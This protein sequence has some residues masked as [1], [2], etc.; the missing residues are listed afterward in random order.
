[1]PN[2]MTAAPNARRPLDPRRISGALTIDR[3]HRPSLRAR[4]M[5][6]AVAVACRPYVRK[7]SGA[8]TP[9]LVSAMARIDA[10]SARMRAPRGATHQPVTVGELAGE[11]VYGAGVRRGHDRAVL[12]LHGG[13]W[14][15]G[16]LNSHRVL[17][18]RISAACGMPALAVSYRMVPH[19]TFRDEIDDCVN[20]YRW[21]LD[22]G[23]AAT[24][25]AII[26]D[27]AGANLA[28]SAALRARSQGI[29]LPAALVG[30]S[31]VYDMDMAAKTAHRN[32]ARDP[33]GFT[34][35]LA[36]LIDAALEG[37]S[38]LH[39]DVSPVRADLRGLPPTMLTV[40]GSEIVYCDSEELASRLAAA[41]APAA[42]QIWDGQPHVFQ[43]LAPF[44]PEGAKSI[45]EIG[46]FVR[47]AI[48]STRPAADGTGYRQ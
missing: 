26:G 34:A 18:S 5:N 15:F 28:L 44:I 6:R 41:G 46:R 47:Q 43:L 36:W 27:S 39:P 3:W 2:S 31:G 40:S 14:L 29:P 37:L 24:S 17:T 7:L 45:A 35:G 4:L 13:G 48:D 10:L 1:M 32:A 12:Y 8:L 42:L 21:L 30:I 25:I 11:W 33:A 16:G 19:V 23:I 20:A 9:E 22:H 38:P